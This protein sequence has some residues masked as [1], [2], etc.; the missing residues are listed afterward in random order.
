MI[1]AWHVVAEETSHVEVPSGKHTKNYGKIH[2]FYDVNQL[3]LWA[4]FN[5]YVTNYQRVWDGFFPIGST[6]S[7]HPVVMDDHDD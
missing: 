5:S 6:P 7:Y 2:H 3:F 1:L 4:I